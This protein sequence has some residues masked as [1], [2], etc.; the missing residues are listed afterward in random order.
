[1]LLT[2][3]NKAVAVAAAALRRR[4]AEAEKGDGLS[5]FAQLYHQY[6][7]RVF[8]F[9]YGRVS[10]KE[11]ALDIVSDIFE[12]AFLKRRFFHTQ[13]AC[14]PWLFSIARNET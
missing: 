12:K 7:P 2:I 6:F 5:E 14:G 10:D 13:D 9:V 1:M 3:A 11:L 8:S 4:A